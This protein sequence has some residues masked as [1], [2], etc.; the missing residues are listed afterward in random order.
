MSALGNAHSWVVSIVRGTRGLSVRNGGA[1]KQPEKPLELYEFESCPFC[2]KVREVMSELDL[3]YISRTT[4]V[5]SAEREALK[6]RG[7]REQ[8]PYLVDPNTGTEMY[9]SED[10]IDYLHETYGQARS[11]AR[12]TVSQVGTSG[13]VVAGMIRPRGR[14]ARSPRKEQPAKMLE[15]YN[16]E[17]SPYCRKVR[18]ELCELDLDYHVKNVAKRSTRRPQLV[19]RG[20]KMMVPYLVDPNTTSE[21]YESDDII[22]YLKKTY[23]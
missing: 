11:R 18:E 8:V 17:A 19:D 15:L 14:R 4:A 21:M 9:E 5:G 2:R 16:M 3:E 20:G 6:S 22:A 10:I 1:R 13:A 23:G 7:G 12:R